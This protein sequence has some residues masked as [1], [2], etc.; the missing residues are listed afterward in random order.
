[1]AMGRVR[2]GR[3]LGVARAGG[4]IGC[5]MP[6]F[7]GRWPRWVTGTPVNRPQREKGPR[8]LMRVRQ[9]GPHGAKAIWTSG[10]PCRVGADAVSPCRSVAVFN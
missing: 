3:T 4:D 5:A 1:M 9:A 7:V 2:V 6:R 8:C 10:S